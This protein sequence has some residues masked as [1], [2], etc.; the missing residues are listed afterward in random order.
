MAAKGS[1]QGS[2]K[3]RKTAAR[4][5]AAQVLY[6]MRL[7]N[8]DAAS[9]LKDFPGSG[10]EFVTA[11]KDLL[12]DIVRGAEKRWEDIDHVLSRALEAGKREKEELLLECILRAGICE[13]LEQG[14]TDAG[15]IINDYLNVTT[16]FYGGSEPKLVNAVLDRVAKSV[17]G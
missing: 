12:S 7:N 14:K 15:I 4:L 5:A 2:A 8:Q 3:A 13:L 16:G 11:D 1:T 10:P 6:Q 9:A 17:R